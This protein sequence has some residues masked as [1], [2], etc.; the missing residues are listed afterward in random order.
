MFLIKDVLWRMR[1]LGGVVY[2]NVHLWNTFGFLV[3]K[4]IWYKYQTIV[5]P[6]ANPFFKDGVHSFLSKYVEENYAGIVEDGKKVDVVSNHTIWVFWWQGKESMPSIVKKCY[7]SIVAHSNGAKVQLITKDNFLQYVEIP[8][9]VIEK[10]N[11]GVLCHAHFSDIY[12]CCLLSK[13]GGLWLDAT[14]LLTADIQPHIFERDFFTM[15]RQP[16]ENHSENNLY[17]SFCFGCKP[18]NLLFKNLSNLFLAYVQKE[19][20]FVDYFLFDYFIELVASHVP[21]VK[22][23]LEEHPYNNPRQ[24]DLQY[25]FNKEF[26]LDWWEKLTTTTTMHKLTY[27]GEL[28]ES[29]G[30]QETIYG[31][32]LKMSFL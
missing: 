8:K 14:I 11:K 16:T 13:Y 22:S 18:G 24:L 3:F 25:N 5:Y 21:S 7:E 9:V 15:R 6:N 28:K 20:Y 1:R 2:H 31:H 19:K 4:L 12:R 27:K 23:M 30:G 32:I 17:S 10:Q 26:N 29:V